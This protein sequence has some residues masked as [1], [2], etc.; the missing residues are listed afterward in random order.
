MDNRIREKIACLVRL[1]ERPGTPHEGEAA[2]LR[3]IELSLK[4]GIPCKFTAG[5]K[6]PASTRPTASAP[7][8]GPTHERQ[9]SDT[10]FY[11]WIQALANVGWLITDTVDTKI[12][13]QIKF[14][15][16]GFNSEIRVIQRRY[17]DGND[18][19]AEYILRPDPDLFGRDRS[20]CACMTTSLKDLLSYVNGASHHPFTIREWE[21]SRK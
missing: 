14:R 6:K 10:I 3:A 15:K 4:Y 20:S 8:P 17:G 11:R 18:F 2:R 21:Y 12:G 16:P 7:Q 9:S 1:A 5:V 19:E 13:R